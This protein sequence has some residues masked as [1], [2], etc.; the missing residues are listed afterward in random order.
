LIHDYIKVE[1]IHRFK[2]KKNANFLNTF[3][4]KMSVINFLPVACSVG[5]Y[6]NSSTRACAA[7]AAGTYQDVEGSIT[8]KPCP[9]SAM[10]VPGAAN[11]SMCE[12]RVY[13]RLGLTTLALTLGISPTF[14][15]VFHLPLTLGILPTVQFGLFINF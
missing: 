6:Y 11:A 12:G 4:T 3:S 10:G 1:N 7:C 13:K 8:C 2:K 15:K 9:H 14:N 5:T